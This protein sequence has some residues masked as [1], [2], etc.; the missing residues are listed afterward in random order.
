LTD[1][2][3]SLAKAVELH[4]GLVAESPSV[5]SHRYLLA[6]SLHQRAEIQTALKEPDKARTTLEE[7]IANLKEIQKSSGGAAHLHMLLSM[8]YGNLAKTLRQLGEKAKA[9]EAA[10]KAKEIADQH[11]PFRFGPFRFG[12]EKPSQPK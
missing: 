5:A 9:D 8:N 12:R 1:A 2:E 3:A 11:G 10:A 7:A 4:K 6:R